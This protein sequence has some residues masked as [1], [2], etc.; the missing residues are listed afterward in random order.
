MAAQHAKLLSN[1][2]DIVTE[3]RFKLLN[4]R[5]RL[6]ALKSK[7]S[8]ILISFRIWMGTYE[9]A[10]FNTRV[11]IYHYDTR[12]MLCFSV[13]GII[14]LLTYYFDEIGMCVTSWN[15]LSSVTTDIPIWILHVC[16][17]V[18]RAWWH[19]IFKANKHYRG[20]LIIKDDWKKQERSASTCCYVK[21]TL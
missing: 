18:Q 5:A 12:V 16:F 20:E 15:D 17:S 2:M 3:H 8:L 1:T 9:T 10:V 4:L 13:S 21:C 19:S 7:E 11:D 6:Q 14:I